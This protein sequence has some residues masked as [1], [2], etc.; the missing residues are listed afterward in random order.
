M[1][2]KVVNKKVK[3]KRSYRRNKKLKEKKEYNYRELCIERL[4]NK[5]KLT[6]KRATQEEEGIYDY[7]ILM[8]ER[9]TLPKKFTNR[10]FKCIYFNKQKSIYTNLLSTSYVDNPNLK[11]RL[12]KQIKPGELA[13][14]SPQELYPEHWKVLLDEKTRRHK[15]QF[16]V[17]K[18]MATDMFQCGR[19]KKWETTYYELQT[20]SGDESMTCFITCV[21]CN[22]KWTQ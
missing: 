19:C 13:T 12:K 8:A 17:R 5:C 10:R 18:E 9:L 15:M 22:K 20:R 6:K 16:E 4:I 14:M 3:K 7:T 1:D 21:N 2:L 11:K